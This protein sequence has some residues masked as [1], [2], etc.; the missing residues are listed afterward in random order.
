MRAT[1]IT[2]SNSLIKLLS[3][4]DGDTTLAFFLYNIAYKQMYNIACPEWKYSG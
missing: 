4:I 1:L 3:K 2:L